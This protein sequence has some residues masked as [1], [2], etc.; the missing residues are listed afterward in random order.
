MLSQTLFAASVVLAS[1]HTFPDKALTG[2]DPNFLSAPEEPSVLQLTAFDADPAVPS[3][4]E[5]RPA[6]KTTDK[7]DDNKKDDSDLPTIDDFLMDSKFP[8]H[9]KALDSLW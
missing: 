9:M 5:L 8:D 6:K 7:K 1:A 4:L 3:A 2:E